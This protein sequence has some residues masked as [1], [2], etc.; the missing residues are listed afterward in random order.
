MR[1]TN[2]PPGGAL[3]AA[4]RWQW[5]GLGTVLEISGSEKK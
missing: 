4:R 3:L 5:R 2:T 1:G